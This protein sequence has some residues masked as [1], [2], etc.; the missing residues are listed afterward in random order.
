MKEQVPNKLFL[1]QRAGKIK[2]KLFKNDN[3][4]LDVC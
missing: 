2:H 1:Y 3:W 4:I